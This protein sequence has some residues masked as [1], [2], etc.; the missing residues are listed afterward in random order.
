VIAGN[1]IPNGIDEIP[2][3]AVAEALARGKNVDPGCARSP[4]QGDRPAG[5]HWCE[6]DVLGVRIAL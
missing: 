4:S 5:G 2:I 1:E 6:F 3:L